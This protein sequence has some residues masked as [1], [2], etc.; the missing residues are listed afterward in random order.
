MVPG[1][2]SVGGVE[3]QKLALDH[4]GL[5]HGFSFNPGLRRTADYRRIGSYSRHVRF[6]PHHPIRAESGL[7]RLYRDLGMHAVILAD[8]GGQG[9]V[10]HIGG[11]Q[12]VPPQ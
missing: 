8:N 11:G 10:R 9:Y 3:V 2:E 4:L 1:V 5:W 12:T 6:D 7:S